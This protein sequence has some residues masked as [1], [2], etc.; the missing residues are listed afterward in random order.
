MDKLVSKEKGAVEE[1][2]EEEEHGDDFE[3][4]HEE[5]RKRR[6]TIEQT[7]IDTNADSIKKIRA[8]INKQTRQK[9]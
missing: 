7:V 2:D 3:S 4:F 8:S 5:E 1:I 6:E 9:C